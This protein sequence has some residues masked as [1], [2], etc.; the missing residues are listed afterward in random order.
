M[1]LFKWSVTKDN[2][3]TPQECEDLIK[4]IDTNG[5]SN[6]LQDHYTKKAHINDR[7]LSDKFWDVMKVANTIHYKWNLSGVRSIGGYF[8]DKDRFEEEDNLHSDFDETD[9]T[10]KMNGLVF[11]NDDFDGGEL[12]IWNTLFKPKVGTLIIF[13]SFA[14]HKVKQFYKK[15]RYT[16]LF[17]VEGDEFDTKQ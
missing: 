5:N 1:R 7:E 9:T 2:F 3:L 15:N 6:V 14:G 11:L 4:V 10:H 16:M 17:V 8:Y 13:P 12:Q